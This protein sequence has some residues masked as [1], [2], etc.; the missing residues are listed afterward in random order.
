MLA[1]YFGRFEYSRTFDLDGPSVTT[2]RVKALQ[3]T[4]R[5]IEDQ[6]RC[7]GLGVIVAVIASIFEAVSPVL[8]RINASADV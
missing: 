4:Q 6:D 2:L 1:A 7:T 3:E 5:A 8:L